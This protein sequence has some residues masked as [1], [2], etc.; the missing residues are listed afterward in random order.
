MKIS[1]LIII[2]LLLFSISA[3]ESGNNQTQ[4]IDNLVF[5]EI[6]ADESFLFEQ[7]NNNVHYFTVSDDG[8]IITVTDKIPLARYTR[9]GDLIEEYSGAGKIG[10]LYYE[11]NI[12][13]AFDYGINKL[14]MYDL[15]TK[16]Q[17]EVSDLFEFEMALYE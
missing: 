16:K 8:E 15:N 5:D 1:K 7:K 10:N 4:D 12:I 14:I 9:N 11:N 6:N 2:I 17:T 3:C 13:Y